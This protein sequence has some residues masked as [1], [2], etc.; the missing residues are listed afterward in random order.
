LGLPRSNGG[1]A[2]DSQHLA[3]EFTGALPEFWLFALGGL[4]VLVTLFLPK[5]IVGLWEQ[6]AAPRR[7]RRRHPRNRRSPH[8]ER[9]RMAGPAYSSGVI[10]VAKNEDWQTSLQ[11]LTMVV[12]PVN[13][14]PI[15][16]T[17]HLETSVSRTM[18]P[19]RLWAL[20]FL[21]AALSMWHGSWRTPA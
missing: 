7:N 18:M 2:A 17:V 9:Q 6:W 12:D 14:T 4:F 10:A 21:L 1:S 5:G 20:A 11:Y 19:P 8:K 13:G 3:S 15:D 16:L